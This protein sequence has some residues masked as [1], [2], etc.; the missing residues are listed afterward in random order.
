MWC[1]SVQEKLQSCVCR[2]YEKKIQNKNKP[3]IG[4]ESVDDKADPDKED[5][6]K[7]KIRALAMWYLS[8]IDRLKYVFSNPRDVELVHWHSKKRR[9][10]D[11][12]IQHPVDVTQWKNFDFQ[13]P[14]SAVKS[15]NIR[16]ALTTDGINPFGENRV[17]HNTWSVILAM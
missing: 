6:T 2:H 4:P 1:E 16:F 5:K 13:Y 10:N 12:V 11:E 3:A 17:V 8:V 14:K 7:R 9:E 15:R